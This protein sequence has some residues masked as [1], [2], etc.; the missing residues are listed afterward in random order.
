MQPILSTIFDISSFKPSSV[1]VQG[2]GGCTALFISGPVATQNTGFLVTSSSKLRKKQLL[3]FVLL[4][5]KTFFSLN[6]KLSGVKTEKL[7]KETTA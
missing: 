3:I 2:G 6:H 1:A 4:Y 7:P 5:V